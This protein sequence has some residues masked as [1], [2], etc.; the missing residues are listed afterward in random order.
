MKELVTVI[1]P[2]SRPETLERCLKAV[3][4]NAVPVK[5]LIVR[6][7]ES[8][9]I[10]TLALQYNAELYD[11]ISK[12]AQHQARESVLK[13]VET[14]YV[15]F[16][17]DDDFIGTRFYERALEAIQNADAVMTTAPYGVGLRTKIFSYKRS[18]MATNCSAFVYRTES[19]K[20]VFD[21]L[22]AIVNSC[23]EDYL[24]NLV[25][26]IKFQGVINYFSGG[27]IRGHYHQGPK[28]WDTHFSEE[29]YRLW[30]ELLN[31]TPPEQTSS[32]V[33]AYF[34]IHSKEARK[35]FRSCVIYS[36]PVSTNL[37]ERRD[38][39]GFLPYNS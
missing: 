38:L 39:F 34:N 17:D 12:T 31:Q 22:P 7:V 27:I 3:R 25:L 35:W 20:R 1:I 21:S 4:D 18:K 6:A 19:I 36:F 24:Y 37:L 10:K 33:N 9:D 15:H 32:N 14:P 8:E 30:F 28:V 5:V 11:F 29:A 16:L 23:G 13:L 26:A 2:A